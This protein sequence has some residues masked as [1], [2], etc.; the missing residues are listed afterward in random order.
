MQSTIT[1]EVGYGLINPFELVRFWSNKVLI[2]HNICTYWSGQRHMQR[3]W[4]GLH[5]QGGTRCWYNYLK[6]WNFERKQGNQSHLLI[7]FSAFWRIYCNSQS[8]CHSVVVK[9]WI[10]LVT[11][12]DQ[13]TITQNDISLFYTYV[14][15]EYKLCKLALYTRVGLNCEIE[16][17]VMVWNSAK[18]FISWTVLIWSFF[19]VR[20]FS[21][22]FDV[23]SSLFYYRAT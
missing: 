5:S 9:Q 12:L 1:L 23:S 22:P 10:F 16:S 13:L 20:C 14:S 6:W 18:R 17:F 4:C 7:F 11:H 15:S 2:H 3:L 21:W 19:T 8:N